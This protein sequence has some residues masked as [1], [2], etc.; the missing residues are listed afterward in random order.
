MKQQL[1]QKHQTKQ[2]LMM[3]H[4]TFINGSARFI[5]QV[6]RDKLR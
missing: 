3:I 4:M 1:N 2:W 6:L 5:P